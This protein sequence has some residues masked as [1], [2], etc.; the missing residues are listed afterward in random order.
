MNA[1]RQQVQILFAKW[2][3]AES[4]FS[5]ELLLIPLD[6]VRKWMDANPELALYRFAIEDLYRQ[7]EHVLDEA[8][9]RLMSLV[10]PPGVV[11]ERRVLRRSRPRMRSFRT[12]TLSNG[13]EVTVSYGQY[14]AI[15]ATRREQADRAA[16]FAA[17]ARGLQGQ[18]EHL[19]SAVQRR[20][21]SATG[22]RRARAATRARSQAALHG[23]NIPTSVVE[24][25]IET[26]RAGVEPLR[27]YHQLRRRV[28]GVPRITSTTSRFRSSPT[29]GSTRTRTVLD[30]IVEAVAP[31]GPDYQ[32]RM[33][34]GLR[35]RLDRRVRERGQAVAARTRR[36][37]TARTRTC[38]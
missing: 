9:E 22:S 11:A 8:G 23:D 7:Q 13:E 38:C 28:L 5:P 1:R 32:A 29:I 36:R 25:L 33:R 35:G 21:A 27:R 2:K 14:R 17:L 16:A 34:E 24:N 18:P 19:R 30:W 6:T 12:I 31:L 4:W 15:L 20:A 26:T 10:E 37:C 3:Q